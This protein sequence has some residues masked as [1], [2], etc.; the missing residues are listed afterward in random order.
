MT[1]LV[2]RQLLFAAIGIVAVLLLSSCGTMPMAHATRRLPEFEPPIAK[3]DIQTVRTTAYTHTEADHIAYGNRNALGGE[4]RAATAPS[5]RAEVSSRLVP[6]AINVSIEYQFGAATRSTSDADDD[7]KPVRKATAAK[8][9]KE[10]KPKK[11]S[12]ESKKKAHDADADDDVP[13]KKATAVQ[14]SKTKSESAADDSALAKKTAKAQAPKAGSS[15]KKLKVK[16]AVAAKEKAR[17]EKNIKAVKRAVAVK[18]AKPPVIGSA[19]ADWARWPVGTTFRVLSTGQTYRVD[20]TGW[21]LAGRN[22]IDL[23]MSSTRDMNE[24][25]TRHEKIQVIKWGDEE[26]SARLLAARQ[27]YKHARRML[28]EL[29]GRYQEAAQ[30]Q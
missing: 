27:D 17:T 10:S 23:Y 20:D 5:R 21:A 1:R 16:S 28:L 13:V 3:A 11:H 22:T 18:K 9:A 15:S 24:W 12:A 7:T 14:A 4:L 29:S 2:L 19:A 26:E 6:R 8:S 30:L 25:G